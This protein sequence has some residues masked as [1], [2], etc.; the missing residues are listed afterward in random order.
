MFS[1]PI[2]YFF[3]I[4]KLNNDEIFI[5]A[6]L[7]KIEWDYFWANSDATTIFAI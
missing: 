1:A 7:V 4:S 6:S 2:D 3:A 5:H